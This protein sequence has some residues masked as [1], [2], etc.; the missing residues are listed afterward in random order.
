MRDG[1]WTLLCVIVPSSCWQSYPTQTAIPLYECGCAGSFSLLIM[2]GGLLQQTRFYPKSFRFPAA[3][4]FV[5]TT[6]T[7]G[8][9]Q[10]RTRRIVPQITF[11]VLARRE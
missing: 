10:S 1:T 11:F 2:K 6:L 3:G 7:M 5:P 9:V 8:Q 4:G